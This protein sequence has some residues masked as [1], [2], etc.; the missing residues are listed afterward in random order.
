LLASAL[1]HFDETEE[2]NVVLIFDVEEEAAE[3][4]SH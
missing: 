3:T 2:I 1:V 4:T